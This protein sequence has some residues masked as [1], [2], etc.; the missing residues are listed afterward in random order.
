MK[1]LKTLLFAAEVLPR[2]GRKGETHGKAGGSG[3]G[4]YHAKTCVEA[5]GGSLGIQSTLGQGTTVAIKLPPA[6]PPAWFV[7][8]LELKPGC[9]VVVLDDDLSIHQVWQGRFDSLRS[10][11]HG[12][13]IF[14]FESPEQL[15][16]WVSDKAPSAGNVLYLLDYEL[17]G[18]Q[19]TGLSLAEEL[20]IGER[21]ILVTSRFEE[22]RILDGCLRLKIRMIPKGMAGFV[23]I[24]VEG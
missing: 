21:A 23:P 20:R 5:W 9:S 12:I 6:Q 11:E 14:D 7:S 4:L 19:E 18:H 3:L 8:K 13:S 16:G 22:R 15:R 10:K 24:S 17:R 1:Q 2:L